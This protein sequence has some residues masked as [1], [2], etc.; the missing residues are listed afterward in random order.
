MHNLQISNVTNIFFPAISKTKTSLPLYLD[1]V[2]AGFPSPASDYEEKRLNPDDYLITN[3]ASTFFARVKGNSMVDAGIF[4]GDVIVVDRSVNPQ[5]GDMVLA[6]MDGD[7]T[8]KYLGK[9]E[10]GALLI[11]ANKEYKTIEVG[12]NPTFEVWGVV[13]GSMRK[14]K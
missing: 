9:N 4:E 13:T 3:K 8:V 11:P 10:N 14:F 7:F 2:Q 5:V 6:V 12:D 1:K